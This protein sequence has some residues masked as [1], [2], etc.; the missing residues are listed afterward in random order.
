MANTNAPFGFKPFDSVKRA[1]LYAVQTAPT[2]NVFVND[3]VAAGNK[4]L[5]TAKLGIAQVIEDANIIPATPGDATPLLGSVLACFD[6]DMDPILYIAA[7]RV[8]DGT[9][10]GYIL[11]ADHPNQLFAAQVQ[12]ALAVADLDLNYEI[13][14]PALS[15]GN[16]S[17]GRSK[18]EIIVAGAGTTVTIPIRI[19]GQY[20][21]SDDT[22]AAYSKVICGIQSECHFWAAGAAI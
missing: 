12:A 19:Y 10:A 16:T 9:V 20:G 17:T 5:I 1:Q 7:A 22:T 8:G 18:Q 3:L 13:Y 6:E 2:I 21:L 4:G 11:V 14:S 15:A